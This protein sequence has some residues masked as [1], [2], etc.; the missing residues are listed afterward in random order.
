MNEN[1]TVKEYE[2]DKP[3]IQKIDSIF[4]SCIRDCHKNCFHTF[5]H[6]C[7][8]DINFT[9]IS[10][11]E[12]FNFTNRRKSM[13]LYKLTKKLTVA[14]QNGFI[15]NQLIKLAIKIYSN[16]S[17]INIHY[18]IKYRIPIMHRHFFRKLSQNREYVQT[19]CN[20]LNNAFRFAVCKWFLYNTVYLHLFKYE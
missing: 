2:F 19:Y 14:R 15:M 1:I 12:T 4:E 5:H 3:L 6:K 13:S 7:V 11:I 17:H 20:D 10:N 9:D 18:Y 8:Y 16:L